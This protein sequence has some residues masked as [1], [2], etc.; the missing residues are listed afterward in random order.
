MT[1]GFERLS[2]VFLG[3]RRISWASTISNEVDMS[4][5]PLAPFH[6]TVYIKHCRLHS[7]SLAV[8]HQIQTSS[9]HTSVYSLPCRPLD[10]TIGDEDI[11]RQVGSCPECV[12]QLKMPPKAENHHWQPCT[13]PWERIHIDFAGPFQNSMF[14]IVID[15]YSKWPE[16]VPMQS[17]TSTKTIERLS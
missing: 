16:V 6:P 5:N 11:E 13:A 17:T 1:R 8:N 9:H 7:H 14:L 3:F 4:G 15:A 2:L 12:E 10:T